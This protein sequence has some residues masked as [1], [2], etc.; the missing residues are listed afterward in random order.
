MYLSLRKTHPQDA[1]DWDEIHWGYIKFYSSIDG[2]KKKRRKEKR[3]KVK[4]RVIER[5]RKNRETCLMTALS[6][7][8]IFLPFHKLET[9]E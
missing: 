3:S 1:S 8:D 7:Q 4:N 2:R 6:E 9:I 5:L